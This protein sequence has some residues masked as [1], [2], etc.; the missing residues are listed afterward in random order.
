[1]C[2]RSPGHGHSSRQNAARGVLGVRERP[3][4]RRI[5]CTVECATPVCPAISRGP[6]PVPRRAWQPRCSTPA[7][8]RR[9]ERRGRLERSSAQA[10]EARSW[11]LACRSRSDQRGAVAGA[12]QRAAAPGGTGGAPAPS[13]PPPP[14]RINSTSRRRPAGP[15]LALAC[16]P[17]RALL[18]RGS[19]ARPTASG[20]ART[21]S[22]TLTTSLGGSASADHGLSHTWRTAAA[23]P[24]RPRSPRVLIREVVEVLAV[25]VLVAGPAG[26]RVGGGGGGESGEPRGGG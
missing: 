26:Q 21:S 14:P 11:S 7:S 24:P 22:Q 25:A 10:P 8:V 18:R 20:R 2:N 3:W 17:I 19:L 5:A 12:T 23:D 16:T 4:R 15:S 9:G 1:M 13:L 6:Q